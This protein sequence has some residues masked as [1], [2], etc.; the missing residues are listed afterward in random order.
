MLCDLM[1]RAQMGDEDA[2]LKLI[3]RFR[4]LFRKYA[5]KLNYEDAYEDIV[6]F[7]IEFIHTVRLDDISSH[8]DEILVSYINTSVI[9]F[10]NKKIHKV[11]EAKKEIPMS[12][13]TEEQLYYA[14]VRL[15]KEDETDAF[16]E[17]GIGDK[18]NQ[19]ESMIIHM[20]YVEGYT[21]AEIARRTKK[22]RQAVNQQKHRAL[23]KLRKIFNRYL[24]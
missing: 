7:F 20:V 12:D 21:I 17:L 15:S 18:L 22:T 6:L 19:N 23:S 9:N 4:P 10:Y 11:I 8:K 13:L 3:E 5:I 24:D 1:K 16:A 14:E 2:M